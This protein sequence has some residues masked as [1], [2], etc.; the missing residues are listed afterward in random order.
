MPRNA[1][2]IIQINRDLTAPYPPV[3][4]A[5][6]G[7]GVAGGFFEW[8]PQDTC[9]RLRKIPAAPSIFAAGVVGVLPAN[10]QDGDTY[11]CVDADASCS[12]THAILILPDSSQVPTPTISGSNAVIPVNPLPAWIMFEPFSGV[13]FT[14]DAPANQW[15]ATASALGNQTF[16]GTVFG[17]IAAGDI[18]GGGSGTLLLAADM[19]PTGLRIVRLVVA[20][21][22]TLSAADTVTAVIERFN[23]VTAF[24]GGAQWGIASAITG[25]TETG[26]GGSG[27]ISITADA[28]VTLQT[29][30]KQVAA[31]DIAAVDLSFTVDLQLPAPTTAG[32]QAAV[33]VQLSTSAANITGITVSSS[34][35]V[36][37]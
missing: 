20:M 37:Q 21:S 30:S 11:E 7:P 36:I 13:S 17:P 18:A 28:P 12:V 4:T 1:T 2:G 26:S 10:P 29:I 6:G 19:V 35:Q 33:G 22:F 24:S 16:Q 34:L 8:S 5:D 27:P 15:I 14:Y 32:A 3:P 31:G 9:L 23:N 25:R